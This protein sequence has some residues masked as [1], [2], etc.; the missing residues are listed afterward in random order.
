MFVLGSG[1]A[2]R[3]TAL[4]CSAFVYLMFNFCF[5]SAIAV[6]FSSVRRIESR[7]TLAEKFLSV[8]ASVWKNP[9]YRS[10]G[11]PLLQTMRTTSMTT[12]LLTEVF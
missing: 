1:S 12:S 3:D 6:S 9:R 11:I 10:G 4:N 5:F 2:L 8:G 7:G